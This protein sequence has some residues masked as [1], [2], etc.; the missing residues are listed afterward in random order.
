[1]IWANCLFVFE[2]FF[3]LEKSRRCDDNQQTTVTHFGE[4]KRLHL[5]SSEQ[6]LKLLHCFFINNNKSNLHSYFLRSNKSNINQNLA[7]RGFG[8]PHR[9]QFSLLRR[10]LRKFQNVTLVAHR[11]KR[12]HRVLAIVLVAQLPPKK[13]VLGHKN[14]F[15]SCQRCRDIVEPRALTCP[16]K[17]SNLSAWSL[18]RWHPT[19]TYLWGILFFIQGV[20]SLPSQPHR[21]TQTMTAEALLVNGF[22]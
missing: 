21:V 9:V 11:N 1:M 5:E 12:L 22:G 3:S 10:Q 16:F 14:S 8:K 18:L 6:T 7:K 19:H 17:Q 4:N 13:S 2:L 15:A 20:C